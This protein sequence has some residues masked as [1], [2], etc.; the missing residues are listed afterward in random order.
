MKLNTKKKIGILLTF[1]FFSLFIFSNIY[2]DP[3]PNSEPCWVIGTVESSDLNVEGLTVE[4]YLSTTLLK[5]G[6]I[7][8][9]DYSLNSVG[10][11]DGDTISLKVYG[12]EFGTF[13]F[14][15]F[16]KTGDDPWVVE[17]FNISKVA[18]GISCS[19]NAICTSGYCSS[20]VCATES[21]GGSPGG[22][23]TSPS[24][25]GTTPPT[26]TPDTNEEVV[27]TPQEV[28]GTTAQ[29]ILDTLNIANE[30]TVDTNSESLSVILEEHI[31]IS[32]AIDVTNLDSIKDFLD[33]ETA[34]AI[35]QIRETVSNSQSL[36]NVRVRAN[37]DTY[38][39]EDENGT[40]VYRTKVELTLEALDD[41]E[42]V[43]YVLVIPKDVAID[44][45][46]LVFNIDPTETLNSDPV[47]KWTFD[48]MTKGQFK[49]LSYFVKKKLD[50]TPTFISV[51]GANNVTAEPEV[52][53]IEPIDDILPVDDEKVK[54]GMKWWLWVILIIAII[55][56]ILMIIRG[57]KKGSHHHRR[58]TKGLHRLK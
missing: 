12:A 11:N 25:G 7:A 56:A 8:S 18:N 19:N 57:S 15:G 6:T 51:T 13:T 45:I 2:A 43:V 24:G 52:D 27:V 54:T 22:G 34:E 10:A 20:S 23:G 39:I 33:T 42:D 9:A 28:T 14:A 32:Q 16:C 55:F 36:R 53:G 31:S 35:E 37:I 49:D 26:T 50:V 3:N 40:E 38:R 4:A 1:L 58:P 21:G 41:I 5:S 48:S 44:V 29:E 17:D 47:V 46:E 30:F